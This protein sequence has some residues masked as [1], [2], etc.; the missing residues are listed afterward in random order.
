MTITSQLTRHFTSIII[1]VRLSKDTSILRIKY[2]IKIL[3]ISISVYFNTEI[4]LQYSIL[5]ILQHLITV[6]MP[7]VDTI[8]LMVKGRTRVSIGLG[9]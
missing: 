2:E 5:N 4:K 1:M 7:Y 6:R 9:L 3:Q 8:R